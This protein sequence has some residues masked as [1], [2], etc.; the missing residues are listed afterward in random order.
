VARLTAVRLRR[1]FYQVVENAPEC[2]DELSMHGFF[3][4]IPKLFRSP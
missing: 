1:D 4:A 3:S 2:F